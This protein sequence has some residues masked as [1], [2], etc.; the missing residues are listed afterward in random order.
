[1]DGWPLVHVRGPSRDTEIVCVDP[2]LAA[3]ERLARLTA[4]DPREMLTVFGRDLTQYQASPLPA[5]LRVERDDEV[6]MTTTLAPLLPHVPDGFSARWHTDGP[7]T[8][9]SLDD[10]TRI[11]AEGTA[12][13]LGTDAVFDGIETSPGHRRR[14][15]GR[16]VMSALTTWAV[17]HG[18]T[19]GLLAASSD[20]TGLYTSLGWTQELAMWSLMGADDDLTIRRRTSSP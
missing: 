11:A 18:A 6:F 15:F 13:V 10:G 5:G 16:H 19:T 17:D 14:G 12:G 20:G 7:R 2:G 3:F 4:H 9:Y 1:V 8:T